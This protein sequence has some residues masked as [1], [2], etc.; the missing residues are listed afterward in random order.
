MDCNNYR[1]IT[2]VSCLSKIFTS[3][4]N[5][6]LGNWS[7]AYNVI[8][9]AQF[10]FKAGYST[11]DAIFILHWLISRSIAKR[12][13]LFCCFV[14]YQKAFDKID[15]NLMFFKLA[16]SGVDCLMLNIIKS[17]YS[18]IKPCVKYQNQISEFFD[19]LEGLM[20]TILYFFQRQSKVYKICLIVYSNTHPSGS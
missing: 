11:T 16:R 6:R 9:N 7:K 1:G 2:L 8:S 3:L 19:C 5:D 4:L 10:G 20:Q 13:K 18:N 14:D 15:R 12:K 17:M